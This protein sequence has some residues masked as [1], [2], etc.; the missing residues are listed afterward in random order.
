M[1]QDFDAE[2]LQFFSNIDT[3]KKWGMTAEEAAR[4]VSENADTHLRAHNV[5][6]YYDLVL[7]QLEGLSI[8]RLGI[9]SQF[10][11]DDLHGLKSLLET[12][13]YARMQP[14]IIDLHDSDF[15]QLKDG[16]KIPI[17][18]KNPYFQK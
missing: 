2:L 5:R 7:T 15:V 9:N 11:C 16:T 17:N 8:S 18:K 14:I 13:P 1:S 10:Y 12:S 3:R 4:V 6:S